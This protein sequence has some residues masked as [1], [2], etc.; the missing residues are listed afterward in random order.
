M[1]EHGPEKITKEERG[2]P[3]SPEKAEALEVAQHKL[4]ILLDDEFK[5]YA[6]R[7]MNLAEY[8]KMIQ[9]G[10]FESREAE[11]MSGGSSFKQ[12]LKNSGGDWERVARRITNWDH[13]VVNIRTYEW[14]MRLMK[15]SSREVKQEETGGDERTKTLRKFR[16]KVLATR[17]H[18]SIFLWG[19]DYEQDKTN[20]PRFEDEAKSILGEDTYLQ[21]DTE[22]MGS[23]TAGETGSLQYNMEEFLRTIS[24][25][26][27][28]KERLRHLLFRIADIKKRFSF[29]TEEKL[30]I[31]H[32]FI[33][34]PNY[35][36][37]GGKVKDIISILS[38]A[39]S[40]GASKDTRQYH[41]M[42]VFDTQAL[43]G[44]Q[45]WLKQWKYLRSAP[46]KGYEPQDMVLGV[47]A[48]I[49]NTDLVNEL[50]E[51]SSSSGRMAHA[52]FDHNGRV[53]Y[54]N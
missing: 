41:V 2:D 53:R 6:V 15:E 36:D 24:V 28:V 32:D 38:F 3:H 31:L 7:F 4:D 33:E 48:L 22:I 54:P 14:L 39:P 30:K 10:E 23:I 52:V 44:N 46:A 47:V 27:E 19:S 18:Y 9:I 35:L 26:P 11:V 34:N 43:S 20:L 17:R 42:A 25:V 12:Y 51:K 1:P 45:S 16:D 50:S 8:E 21:I 29:F 13:G 37:D 49:P 5:D 40:Y